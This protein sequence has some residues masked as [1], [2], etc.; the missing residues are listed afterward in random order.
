[1]PKYRQRKKKQRTPYKGNRSGGIPD[2]ECKSEDREASE[3]QFTCLNFVSL[4]GG[5]LHVLSCRSVSVVRTG[6]VVY[7]CQ[8]V[9]EGMMTALTEY[10]NPYTGDLFCLECEPVVVKK[11][12]L[13]RNIGINLRRSN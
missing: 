6:T 12:F 7:A 10:I 11:A 4:S 5:T 2:K 1:M 3:E 9:S 8:N 13:T